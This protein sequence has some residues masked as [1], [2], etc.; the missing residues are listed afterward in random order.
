MPGGAVGNDTEWVEDMPVLLN[1]TEGIFFLKKGSDGKN[2]VLNI[3]PLINGKTEKPDS[4]LSAS[5]LGEFKQKI[6]AVLQGTISSTP[7]PISPVPA[8]TKAGMIFAPVI[9]VIGFVILIQTRRER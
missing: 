6:S 1:N 4:Q 9:A 3:I 8:T 5:T 7:L 2:S